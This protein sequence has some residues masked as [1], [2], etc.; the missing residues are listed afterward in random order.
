MKKKMMMMMQYLAIDIQ[1]LMGGKKYEMSPEDYV[2][3]AAQIFVD[4]VQ[5]FMLLLQIVGYAK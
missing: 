1:L 2:F 5:I 3:A 4:I